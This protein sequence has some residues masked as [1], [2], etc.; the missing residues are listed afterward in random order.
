MLLIPAV[1]KGARLLT[2]QLCVV[3]LIAW[4]TLYYTFS[5]FLA[6]MGA[7]LGWSNATLSFGFSS[8]LVVSGLS[9]PFVGR[10]IDRRG[11]REIMSL[12]VLVGASGLLLWTQAETLPVYLG[13]WLLI[14]L[15]MAGSL[16]APAFATLVCFD[17]ETH[18]N[19]ILIVTLVGALAATIFFPLSTLLIE[20][21]GWRDA[22]MMLAALLLALALPGTLMIPHVDPEIDCEEEATS[23]NLVDRAPRAFVLVTSSLTLVDIAGTA[24]SVYLIVFLMEQG[25]T[26]HAAAAIAGCAGVAKIVGRF[27]TVFGEHISALMLYRLSL[28]VTAGSILLPLFWPTIWAVVVMVVA[29]GAMGGARTILRPLMVVELFGRQSFG[30]SN[31]M[32]QLFVTIGNSGAPVIMGLLVATLGWQSSWGI[33]A[34][35]IF[36]GGVL[37]FLVQT[38]TT[39]SELVN[40]TTS[41]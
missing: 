25:L 22:L 32:I 27:V 8:A 39:N 40:A 3:E 26:A 11:S 41:P 20:L 18:R 15:G 6:P 9:A 5:V 13:A 36:L 23:Q 35:V 17:K 33:G 24:I 16:Y 38:P 4:G 21:H 7:D 12:G 2:G 34:A 19:G 29:F 37:L 31:G 1:N 14:G 30:T 28:F 10:W